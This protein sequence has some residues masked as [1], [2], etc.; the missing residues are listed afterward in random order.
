MT[1]ESNDKLTRLRQTKLAAT[2]LLAFMAAI[3]AVSLEFEPSAPWLRFVQ[4]F[5]EAALVGGL[6]DWFAV[7]AL[8]RHPLGLPIPHTAILVRRKDAIGEALARFVEEN[9]LTRE[10]VSTKLSALD[11][12]RHGAV[13][14]KRDGNLHKVSTSGAAFAAGLGNLFD[15]RDIRGWLADNLKSGLAQ[16]EFA[17]L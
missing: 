15:A 1:S 2:G 12:V 11:F 13:W 17:P 4:A 5:T 9:F 10:A 3:F 8:F 16:I 6:A 14:L 7:T